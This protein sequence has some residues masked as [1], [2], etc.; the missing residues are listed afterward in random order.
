MIKLYNANFSPNCLRVRAVIYEL[1]TAVEI[2]DVDVMGGETKK[3]EYLAMNPHGKVPVLVD[4]DLFLF[5]S[6]A[7]NAYLA[8]LD[9]E[10]RLYPADSKTRA[11]VDQWSYWQAIHLGPSSQRLTFERVFKKRLQRGVPDENVIATE[12][13]ET[14]KLLAV[15]NAGLEERDWVAGSLSVAD[16]ALGST[17]FAHA[18]AGIDLGSTPNVSA[19]MARLEA[20]PSWRQA[21]DDIPL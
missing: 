6:R 13:T 11:V 1:G 15:L 10:S 19:W 16:F 4:G 14:T 17:L 18:P 2:V 21:I 5:E 7:I 20:L 12:S 9:S 3:P 8:S